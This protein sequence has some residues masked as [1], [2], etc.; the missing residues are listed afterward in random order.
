[1]VQAD[2]ST[3]SPPEAPLVVS[4][5]SRWYGDVVAVS[6]VSF[7][8]GA[9]ITG[10]LGPNGAGKT[11]LLKM[12]AGL[13]TPSKGE[14]RVLGEP[15][16]GNPS[17][18]RHISLV[19]EHEPVYPFMTAREFVRFNARLQGVADA[20]PVEEALRQVDLLD[21]ADRRVG[22]FSKGMHQRTKLAGAL[23]H[24]PPVLLLDEPFSGTDPRQRIQLMELLRGWAGEGRTVLFS[25]H[26]LEEVEQLAGEVVVIVGGKLA[27]LG[28]IRGIRAAMLDRPHHV[29][30]RASDP[31]RFAAALVQEPTVQ[32]VSLDG[33]GVLTVRAGELGGA[34]LAI[35]RLARDNAIRLIEVYPEDES[36]ESVFAYL[37]GR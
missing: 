9:G 14:V 18:Y 25:S 26:I 2:S 24:Q 3:L 15:V 1:M 16:R 20:A 11:T 6:D 37:V 35:P 31:R 12:L 7:S 5:V 17:I 13:L 23:V 10:L 36:L 34:A 22:G 27:A 19:M 32:G 21:V 4:H 33:D 28:G 8:V 29:R 30:I